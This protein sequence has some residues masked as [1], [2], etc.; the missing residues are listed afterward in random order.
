M[1]GQYEFWSQKSPQT[2]LAHMMCNRYAK[3][4]TDA[5]RAS[6]ATGNGGANARS[7]NEQNGEGACDVPENVLFTIVGFDKDQL[8]AVRGDFGSQYLL[9]LCSVF[10]I[11]VRR[12]QYL[13]K[14]FSSASSRD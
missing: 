4:A 8:N 6:S 1:M 2:K 9:F 3:A 13:R 11:G 7:R 10:V 5:S 12:D 14:S